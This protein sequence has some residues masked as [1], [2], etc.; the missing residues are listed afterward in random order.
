M[1]D[2]NKKQWENEANRYHI[3]DDATSYEMFIYRHSTMKHLCG[4][5]KLPQS[6]PLYNK[7]YKESDVYDEIDVHGGVTFTDTLDTG[8]NIDVHLD[9]DFLVGFDCAHAGDLIPGISYELVRGDEVYRDVKYV[10]DEL[11]K[12]AKQLKEMED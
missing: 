7:S 1:T 6:H 3:I 10:T 11:T 9:T 4:Y 2:N 5:V 12:L 8:H